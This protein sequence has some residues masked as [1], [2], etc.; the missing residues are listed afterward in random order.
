MSDRVTAVP[1][2]T[3]TTV[4]G[5]HDDP[6]DRS[7]AATATTRSPAALGDDTIDGGAGD[8][9]ARRLRRQRHAPRRRRQRRR[10]S[11]NTGTDTISRRRRHRH[12]GLRPARL[13]GLLARRP[14]QRRR[15]AGENDLI[16]TDVEN[17][18]GAA[19]DAGQTV[20]I[21]GDGRANRLTRH[22]RQG[23]HHRRRRRRRPRGRP[24]GRHDQRAR[25]LARHRHLQ[26]RHRH[27]ARRHARHD[28]AQRARTCRSQATPG[29]PFDDRPPTLAW[30]APGRGAS[31]SAERRDDAARR[32]DRRPRRHTVQFFDDDRVVCE[33]HDR[34]VRLR[35]PAARR[36]R[37]PQHADRGRRRRRRPDHERRARRSPCAA[38]R[39]TEL[40]ARRCGPSRDRTRAVHLPRD[41]HASL[42]PDD[43]LAVA[44]LLGH[45]HA[46]RQARLEGRLDHA[47]RAHAHVR[48]HGDRSGSAPGPRAAS[49]CRPS[50]AATTCSR[51]SR[52]GPAPPAWA[53]VPRAW[54]SKERT[55]SSP[56]GR[57]ASAPPRPARCTPPAPTSRSPTSNPE[58]GARARRRARRAASSPPTSPTRPRS[59]P[60]SSHAAGEDGL[61]ITR[62]L[63]RHRPGREDRRPQG[64]AQLRAVRDR[65]PR[66]PDRQLQRAAPRGRRRCSPTTPDAE[67]ER[68]VLHQHRLDRRLRRP[69]RPGRLRGLQGRH[70]RPDAARRARPRPVRHPRLRDRPGPVRHA[71]ARRPARGGPHLAR[72]APSRS[73]PA[74]AARTSTRALALHI[75]ENTM[76]NGEVIRLDGAL[77]MAPR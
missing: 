40:G 16:G 1:S 18:E 61:R 58:R 70:R 41:R 47:R 77:R 65:D 23:R 17:I 59:R 22:V 67:G 6:D 5:P 10:C 21:I 75:V 69:D 68:G 66:Q 32:R 30:T 34:A 52:R 11:P 15:R 8:D 53:S 27:R 14:R 28:L 2:T 56:A 71:A 13:A 48:V 43:R 74:S 4:V 33:D 55:H 9:D 50:S 39:R 49:A 46:H 45:G 24:A 36:R 42:R 19:D 62:L 51:R 54:T 37:R 20:T 7:A 72:R 60:P 25:R 26:R 29:G 57:P 38:S 35:L 73:R 44:G 31:L 3:P 63:R 76:L 64:P 12:R